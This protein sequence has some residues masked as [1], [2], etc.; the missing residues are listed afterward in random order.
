MCAFGSGLSNK[1]QRELGPHTS[2]DMCSALEELDKGTNEGQMTAVSEEMHEY[3]KCRWN[4]FGQ[5]EMSV[6]VVS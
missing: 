5:Q 6:S 2:E 3:R 4:L 1:N